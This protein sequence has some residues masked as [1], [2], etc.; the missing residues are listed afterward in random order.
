MRDF[1][2]TQYRLYL[3]GAKNIGIEKIHIL[4]DVFMTETEKQE[5]FSTTTQSSFEELPTVERA[6]MLG[7]KN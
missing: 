3:S 2:I 5:L 4:A 1:I 6:P 7:D